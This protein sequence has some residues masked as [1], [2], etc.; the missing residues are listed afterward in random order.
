MDQGGGS[1]AWGPGRGIVRVL[2]IGAMALMGTGGVAVAAPAGVPGP[3]EQAQGNGPPAT[4]PATQNAPAPQ[5][6]ARAQGK[7]NGHQ[8][9][10][11]PQGGVQGQAESRGRGS[12]GATGQ[13]GAK[14]HAHANGGGQSKTTTSGGQE[15][16]STHSNAG[17]VTL[18][19]ATGSE[20]NPYAEITISAN[21]LPAH[22]RHQDGRDIYPAPPGGC[23]GGTSSSG[24]HGQG[25]AQ[26]HGKVTICHATGSETNPYVLITVDEHALKAHTSHQDG[27]DIVNPTGPCPGATIP[28]GLG[29]PPSGILSP[30]GG[31]APG[32]GELAAGGQP[33]S[34]LLGESEQGE[35]GSQGAP[36]EQGAVLGANA[37]GGNEAGAA[38][39]TSGSSLPFTGLQL[40]VMAAAGLVLGLAGFRL[41]RSTA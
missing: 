37:G 40:L 2:A 3:P 21:A 34:G 6:D 36:E 8:T 12:V 1:A 13:G 11:S 24:E 25:N 23:P 20:T 4:T 28:T 27:E 5:G 33:G 39:D 9:A 32:S 38:R 30:P 14:G 29:N 31:Q 15:R 19:H 7:A 17:K 35:L 18:C 22:Q 16:G 10:A 26:E 41:R